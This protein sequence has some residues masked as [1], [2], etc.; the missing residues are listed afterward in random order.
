M[1]PKSRRIAALVG[2][3]AVAGVTAT[4]VIAGTASAA[5][6]ATCTSSV[7]VRSEPSETAPIVGVCERGATTTV[8]ETRNGFVELPEFGG[9]ALDDYVSTSSSSSSRP[10]TDGTTR[11]EDGLTSTDTPRSGERSTSPSTRTS[12]ASEDASESTSPS[13][14]GRTERSG[15]SSTP[16]SSG[17]AE[18]SD[19]AGS[20]AS[21][22]S[23]ER[24]ASDEFFS[25]ES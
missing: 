15:S 8:G 25:D 24:S 21:P 9:W 19:S 2:A 22:R 17:S 13:G 16:R 11:S 7:N 20:S 10:A 1:K 4:G 14:E 5:G 12:P 18:P 6:T 3:L 23:A